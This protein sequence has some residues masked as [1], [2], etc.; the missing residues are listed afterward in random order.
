MSAQFEENPEVMLMT[1]PRV[2]RQQNEGQ[3][4]SSVG[5]P[6]SPVDQKKNRYGR[7]LAFL[8][9]SGLQFRVPMSA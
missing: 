1:S 7:G 8:R 9:I 3:D 4:I 2:L 6:C 5:C